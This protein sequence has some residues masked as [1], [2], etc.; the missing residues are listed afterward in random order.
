MKFP[1]ISVIMPAY[2]HDKYIGEAIESVL[3]QSFTDFEFIIINDGSTDNTED[4]I[5]HYDDNRIR[6]F[7]QENKDAYNAIN[8]GLSLAKGKYISIINSDDVYHTDRLAY[9]FDAIR[10]RNL[11]FIF[12]NVNLIN[13]NS[14]IITDESHISVVWLNRLLSTYERT[15]SI[16]CAFLLGNLAVTT[17][18][19]FFS[20]DI[21]REIGGFKPYR[22]SHDYEYALRII[23]KYKG[24]TVFV[25]HKKYLDYRV[26]AKNTIAKAPLQVVEEGI[27]ILVETLPAFISDKGEAQTVSYALQSFKENIEMIRNYNNVLYQEKQL[28]LDALMNSWSWKITSPLRKLCKPFSKSSNQ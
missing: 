9:L 21:V 12:T 20:S 26:H 13:E 28:Q 2:N 11:N 14:E 3:N 8:T 27:G 17:S 7:A 24:K 10:T 18:N 6:Y 1:S 23:S 15:G 16:E 5:R 22:Y 19:Y 25:D 4:V